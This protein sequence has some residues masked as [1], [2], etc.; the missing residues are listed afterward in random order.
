MRKKKSE[1]DTYANSASREGITYGKK[2][3]REFAKQIKIGPIP[4]GYRKAGRIKK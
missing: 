3:T 4:K 1:L 2:Q